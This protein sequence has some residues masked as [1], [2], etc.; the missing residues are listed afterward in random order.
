MLEDY[1]NMIENCLSDRPYIKRHNVSC[2]EGLAHEFDLCT[3]NFEIIFEFEIYR[4]D[5]IQNFLLL[6]LMMTLSRK[7]VEQFTGCF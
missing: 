2:L 6:I 4:E 5:D 1:C 7:V 3:H